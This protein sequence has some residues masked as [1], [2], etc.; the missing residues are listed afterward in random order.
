MQKHTLILWS[1]LT[2]LV[3]V[4]ANAAK[5]VTTP[6][7]SPARTAL[8][9]IEFVNEW[10]G[11]EAGLDFLMED[12]EQ[13]AASREA[14]RQAL[15][16]ARAHDLRVV[17]ATLR[18]SDD[19]RE[20][21][22][23]HFGLRAAI[24]AVGTWRES[25]DGWRFAEG[26]TPQTDEF[27][28][29]GRTGASAFAGGNLAAYLRAQGITQLILAGY[30]LHVCVESTLRDAHDRGYTTLVLEEATAAFTAAQR[31]HVL[32]HVIHHYGA[33]LTVDNFRD[34]LMHA[35]ETGPTASVAAPGTPPA[36]RP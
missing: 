17:H 14:G 22:E 9:M 4:G 26:F 30:A 36:A 16:I 8:I 28:V 21:G 11:P 33:R 6:P 7:E 1:C 29:D 2:L 18:L 12:R 31:Q 15:E 5:P 27:V 20:F 19:Y 10:L 32:D 3:A 13:F 23:A 35:P 34:W 25:D 24:P